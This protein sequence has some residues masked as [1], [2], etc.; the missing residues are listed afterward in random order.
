MKPFHDKF[1]AKWNETLVA[2]LEQ[3]LGMKLGDFTDLPQGQFTFA[4][5][6]NGWNGT[7]DQSP[8]LVLLLDAKDKS[9]LLK[10]NLAALQKNGRTAA[11]PSARKRF[12]A[13][14]SPSCRFPATTFRHPFR[15][16]CPKTQPVSELGKE[17]QSE[18][19]GEMVVG[20]FESLLI[21][22]NSLK[23]VEPV[24]AHL[25]GGSAPALADNAV[26]AA[27]KL[28][29]F[30]GTPLYYGW[31]N[32]KTFFNV[33][34]NIPQAEP[35]PDAPSPMP[36]VSVE[37]GAHRVRRDGPEERELHLPRIA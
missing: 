18:K 16:C 15:G 3:D 7:G 31:F 26:F 37:Q 5:T 25:T 10:T 19:P 20:Q 29:Q 17:P 21:V 35:N 27:D 22:G 12:V 36:A 2:P 9:D 24:V 4:V 11:N 6:Q 32:A 28:A 23:A 1:M 33:L 14:I 30:R 34:A 13:S 8:G